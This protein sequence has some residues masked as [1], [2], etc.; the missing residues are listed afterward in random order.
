MSDNRDKKI[1]ATQLTFRYDRADERAV[2]DHISCVVAAGSFLAVLGPNGS[3]KT[4]LLRAISGWLKPRARTVF[5]DGRDLLSFTRAEVARRLATVSQST[6]SEAAFTVEE[7][8]LMGRA[9]H[10]GF[11]QPEGQ[12]DRAKIDEALAYTDMLH[13]RH[14]D[15]TEL[16]GGE[17][18]RVMI[19]QALAQDTAVL[20]LDEPTAHLDLSHQHD[21]LALL[22]KMRR[23]KNLTV[24]AALHDLNSAAR[25]AD[26]IILLKLGK[27]EA[28]GRPEDVITADIIKRVYGAEVVVIPHPKDGRPVVIEA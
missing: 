17:L 8:V 13:L 23:E 27:I 25:Y 4:T 5:I 12:A 3:G 9:P 20:L 22:E 24:V 11:L 18:K 7:T 26:R 14:R 1:E 28:E 21:I 15:V 16:S 2:L 6:L 10:L 19:A